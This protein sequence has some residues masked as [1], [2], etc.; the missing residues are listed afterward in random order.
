SG[1]ITFDPAAKTGAVDVV[2]DTRSVDTGFPLFNEHIQGEDYLDTARYPTATFR[3]TAVRFEG[4]RPVAIDGDLTLKGVTK[5]VTLTVTSFQHMPHPML[6]RD[7]IGA[8]ASTTIKRSEF[9]A[10]KNAPYVGDEVTIT[11]AVEAIQQ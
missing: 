8:N 5:P 9:N 6:K 10:G 4:D 11:I 3:S 1:K 2:I 7:A